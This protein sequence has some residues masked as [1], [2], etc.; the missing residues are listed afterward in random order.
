MLDA[1]DKP[2]KPI[3][4][5]FERWKEYVDLKTAIDGKPRV[6]VEL[7]KGHYQPWLK[8]IADNS[9]RYNNQYVYCTD[10]TP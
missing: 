6:V 3:N 5:E 8:S 7:E 9:K 1:M 4:K 2:K 10:V